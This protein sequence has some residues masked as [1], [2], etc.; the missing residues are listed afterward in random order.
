MIVVFAIEPADYYSDQMMTPAETTNR[1]TK[2]QCRSGSG[3]L[4][5][6][7][8]EGP[9]SISIH[10]LFFRSLRLSQGFCLQVEPSCGAVCHLRPS[11]VISFTGVLVAGDELSGD[12][13]CDR[14]P[15]HL[16]GLSSGTQNIS[17]GCLLGRRSTPRNLPATRSRPNRMQKNKLL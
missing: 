7:P 1:S 2:D 4:N 6:P 9:Q 15:E 13:V 3:T 8:S 14:A 16:L 5:G 11:V 17:L 12:K 10:P